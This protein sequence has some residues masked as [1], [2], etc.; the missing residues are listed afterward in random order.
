MEE[1]AIMNLLDKLKNINR[2]IKVPNT[3]ENKRDYLAYVSTA[4]LISYACSISLIEGEVGAFSLILRGIEFYFAI[5]CIMGKL[6]SYYESLI[7]DKSRS[8]IIIAGLAV[9][10][11]SSLLVA[12]I[13]EQYF[14]DISKVNLVVIKDSMFILGLICALP[15]FNEYKKLH[16]SGECN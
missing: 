5:V 14:I 8:W 13:V 15:L 16:K 9:G 11:L 4:G 2:K 12:I 10:F 6:E 1:I 7:I 3:K